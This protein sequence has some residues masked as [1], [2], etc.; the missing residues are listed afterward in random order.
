MNI[1]RVGSTF[2]AIVLASC[3]A[4]PPAR[5]SAN[6]DSSAE[7]AAI[8]A[9]SQAFDSTLSLAEEQPF[10]ALLA[11]SVLW[12]VPN[13]P[14]LVGKGAVRDRIHG[15]FAVSSLDHRTTIHEIRVAGDWAY[16]RVTY[17]MSITPKNGGAAAEEIGKGINMFEK[18]PNG[19]WLVTRHIW[20]ADHPDR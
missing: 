12:M 8:R 3:Q 5:T 1:V 9:Q 4:T 20:N 16:A 11:D 10:L 2:L 19:S 17:R 15:R 14:S 7:L 13:Q 6:P 18:A